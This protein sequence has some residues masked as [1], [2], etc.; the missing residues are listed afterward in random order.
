MN[1]G[2]RLER[3]ER[4]CPNGRYHVISGWSREE[5]DMKKAKLRASGKLAARDTLLSIA[6]IDGHQ[7]GPA[8]TATVRP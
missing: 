7:A 2:A 6:V 3:I 5:V 4:A 8:V 1:I